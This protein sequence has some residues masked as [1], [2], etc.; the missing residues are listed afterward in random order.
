MSFSVCGY[1]GEQTLYDGFN[2][3][4]VVSADRDWETKKAS[5]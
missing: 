1:C 2:Y 4:G 3:H 5:Y